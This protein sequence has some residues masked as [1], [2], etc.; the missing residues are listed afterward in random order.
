[1]SGIGHVDPTLKRAKGEA[2]D[3]KSW[4]ERRRGNALETVLD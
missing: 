3:S 4:K 2:P 1:M